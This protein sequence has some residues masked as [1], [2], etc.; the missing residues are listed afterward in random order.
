MHRPVP[1]LPAVC[2]AEL[3][4]DAGMNATVSAGPALAPN[5][6]RTDCTH[7]VPATTMESL[8]C[9]STRELGLSE[10]NRIS[11]LWCLSV[12]SPRFESQTSH[13]THLGYRERRESDRAL[14]ALAKS[15]QQPSMSAELGPRRLD[16]YP[17]AAASEQI[18]TP[19]DRQCALLDE[20]PERVDDHCRVSG[21][22]PGGTVS[23]RLSPLDTSQSTRK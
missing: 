13:P 14:V 4:V 5:C 16:D 21:T 10:L 11:K 12:E 9:G 20:G 18:S 6:G 1:A 2:T 8:D 19:R 7:Q 3:P 17:A 15:M 22:R 23:V